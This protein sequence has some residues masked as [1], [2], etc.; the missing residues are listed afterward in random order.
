MKIKLIKCLWNVACQLLTQPV[1]QL[2]LNWNL[3]FYIEIKLSLGMWVPLIKT[4]LIQLG[5]ERL[6]KVKMPKTTCLLRYSKVGRITAIARFYIKI[7]LRK[8]FWGFRRKVSTIWWLGLLN[9]CINLFIRKK[10][11]FLTKSSCELIGQIRAIICKW[12][13]SVYE[14][15]YCG[16]IWITSTSLINCDL[17]QI[18]WGL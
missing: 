8:V 2:L 9:P 16:P 13:N 14:L 11:F 6:P 17:G 15:R 18:C 3:I 1:V 4:H 12:H 10:C 5:V 7:T